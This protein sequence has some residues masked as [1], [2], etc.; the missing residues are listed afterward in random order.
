MMQQENKKKVDNFTIILAAIII[1]TALSLPLGGLSSRRTSDTSEP[2]PLPTTQQA[3][4]TRVAHTDPLDATSAASPRIYNEMAQLGRQIN[5]LWENVRTLE[6]QVAELRGILE[7]SRA[8][9]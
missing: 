7:A 6:L 5:T 8:S 1:V 4:T 3:A 2:A 9:Q